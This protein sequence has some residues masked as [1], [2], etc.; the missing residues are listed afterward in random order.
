M[1]KHFN[2]FLFHHIHF[3]FIGPTALFQNMLD[4]RQG[5]YREKF[6]EQEVTGKE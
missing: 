6:R 2:T 1:C 3:F 4:L 5:N